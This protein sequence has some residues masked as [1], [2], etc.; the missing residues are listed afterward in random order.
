[1]IRLAQF[2]ST[3]VEYIPGLIPSTSVESV[4]ALNTLK[5]IDTNGLGV[6][7]DTE[8]LITVSRENSKEF[9]AA[10]RSIGSISNQ[11]DKINASR[12][13][14]T[15]SLS[16]V[17]SLFSIDRLAVSDQIQTSVAHLPSSSIQKF[18]IPSGFI[19]AA[20]TEQVVEVYRRG[21]MLAVQSIH[22]ILR[23]SYRALKRL[24][25][26][27]QIRVDDGE[28]ITVVGDIHGRFVVFS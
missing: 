5:D 27:S 8:G 19:T 9:I 21:G 13:N 22:K 24:P 25:N 17:D 11:D 16:S 26:I 12:E 14:S 3:A 4:V 20:V 23:L 2:M 15:S 18:E 1:M 10:L 28:T 6:D 7:E